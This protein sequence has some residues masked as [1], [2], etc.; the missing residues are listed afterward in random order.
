MSMERAS[1]GQPRFAVTVDFELHDGAAE[2]FLRLVKANAAAS[3]RDEP[4]CS[5]FDV[6]TPHGEPGAPRRVFLYEIYD[7]P[8]AFVEHMNTPHFAE[9][10][11][12]SRALV[13]RKTVMEFDVAEGGGP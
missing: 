13:R 4:G 7:H 1:E 10:D 6:L 3:V 12:A 2:E 8:A 9:F 5:R 11:A